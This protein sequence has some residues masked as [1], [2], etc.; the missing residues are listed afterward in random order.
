MVQIKAIYKDDGIPPAL[1]AGSIEA[2]P[3]FRSRVN[4]E[5]I[6]L[7]RLDSGLGLNHFSYERVRSFEAVLVLAGV[8]RLVVQTKAIDGGDFT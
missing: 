6:R 4:L 3:V 1:R 8:R 7:S 5:R 2:S